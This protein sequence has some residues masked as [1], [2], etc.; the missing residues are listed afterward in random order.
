MAA[1]LSLAGKLENIQKQNHFSVRRAF[2]FFKCQAPEKL[3]RISSNVKGK[4]SPRDKKK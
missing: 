1:L 3:T 4:A 2:F